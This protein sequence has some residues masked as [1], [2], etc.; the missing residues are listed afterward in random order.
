MEKQYLIVECYELCDQYECDADR[1]P[2]CITK[3]Y[4]PYNDY[5]YEIYEILS[6]GKL[7]LVK[8]YTKKRK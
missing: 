8:E 7:K 6:N 3:S 5:G 2:I 4:K 1:R